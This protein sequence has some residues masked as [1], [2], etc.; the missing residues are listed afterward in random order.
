MLSWVQYTVE[1]QTEPPP[2][3]FET[4]TLDQAIAFALKHAPLIQEASLTVALAELDLKR[5]QLWRRFIPSLTVHQGYNPIVGES[6]LGIGLSLD[7]NRIWEEDDKAKGAKL[8]WLNTEMYRKT[9]QNRVILQVTQSYYDWVTAQKQVELL[10][11]QL[12]TQLKLQALQKLQF[13]SGQAQLTSVLNTLDAT[14]TTQLALLKAQAS[15]KLQ[16][17]TLQSDIGWDKDIEN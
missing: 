13:E 1:A 5:T 17:L 11:D 16:E 8:K 2:L 9:V 12:S 14:A 4:L 3:N 7:F 10:E 6:R 15:V